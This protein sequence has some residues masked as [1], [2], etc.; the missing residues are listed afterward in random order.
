M[1]LLVALLACALPSLQPLLLAR[2][3]PRSHRRS[4]LV[5][6]SAPSAPPAVPDQWQHEAVTASERSVLVVA[7][8]G[9]GKTR[10]LASRLA[11]L[12]LTCACAPRDVLVLSFSKGAALNLRVKAEALLRDSV[13]SAADVHCDSFHGFCAAVLK[14]H[15]HMLAD[16]KEYLIAND[17]YQRRIMTEVL[18]G[19]GARPVESHVKGVL[20][21][22]RLWKELGLGYAGVR[23]KSLV[24]AVEVEAYDAYPE[25]QRKLRSLGCLDPGDL[26]LQTLRL[27]RAF[28]QALAEYRAR[29]SHVL[30]DEFQ[31]V[32]A[33][34]YDVLRLLANGCADTATGRTVRVFCAGDDDQSVY[35][36]R[37]AQLQLMR[38]FKY[39]FADAS[40]IHFDTTYR[41][42]ERINAASAALA[43]GL[44]DRIPKTLSSVARAEEH[45][46]EPGDTEVAFRQFRCEAEELRWL[47]TQL[48]VPGGRGEAAVLVR[49]GAQLRPVEEA[50]ALA[51]VSVQRQRWGD[52]T[53]P[54]GTDVALNLL[55]LL[56]QPHDSYA[57]EAA[58]RNDLV[59]AT[60]TEQ[61]IESELLPAIRQQAAL[62]QLTHMDAARQ[63]VL[64]GMLS[65]PLARALTLFV[66]RLDST[67]AELAR[68]F[69]PGERGRAAVLAVLRAFLMTHAHVSEELARRLDQVA[70]EVARHESLA[71]FVEALRQD[72]PEQEEEQR[73]GQVRVLTMHGAKGLEF[74]TVYLPHWVQGSVPQRDTDDERRLAFVSLTRARRAVFVS[75]A[76]SRV[77]PL[78]A[79][80]IPAAPS[81][82]IAELGLVDDSACFG[83][84]ADTE[85][86]AYQAASMERELDVQELNVRVRR[87]SKRR[88]RDGTALPP[89]EELTSERVRWLLGNCD[90]PRGELKAYFRSAV[91][92]R[93]GVAR[94]SIPLAGQGD[95][96]AWE[97]RAIS[98]CS[99]EQLG[100]FLA[101]EL[102]SLAQ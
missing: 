20:N 67:R 24:S 32:S 65:A 88:R 70:S 76:L 33:A 95:A 7:G 47:A 17:D 91:C 8:P 93:L 36:W 14:K 99:A 31:D 39:D 21:Q 42:P 22:I 84:G 41:L 43:S 38:R 89:A 90:F 77:E 26:L 83:L 55:R 87:R 63:C 60:L 98:A 29:Y 102:E 9:S 57:F 85:Y 80:S 15:M 46:P 69:V 66:S 61:Q 28:P 53:P 52:W 27:F 16:R 49:L 64:R 1:W 59:L 74:D 58:L 23:K 25:Y 62:T 54:R 68:G 82:Y 40:V 101:Q 96:A 35:A 10:V 13:A 94:G 6:P 79:R 72:R 50:L 30:V 97:R 4:A 51:G 12:L 34:Q 2:A 44:A 45:S 48:A 75:C 92:A 81:K 37:G 100:L 5:L 86:Q 73:K 78:S 18:A 11:W 71:A 3:P 19:K 56:A